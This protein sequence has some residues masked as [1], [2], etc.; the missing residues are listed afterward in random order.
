M[1]N[2]IIR[3]STFLFV[4]ISTYLVSFSQVKI[5]TVYITDA[6]GEKETTNKKASFYRVCKMDGTSL[7]A[8]DYNIDDSIK[9]CSA[10][11]KSF[12]PYVKQGHFIDYNSE[13]KLNFE[14]DYFENE[15]SGTW[16][17]YFPTGERWYTQ[18]YVD[19]HSN[20]FLKSYFKTGEVK[21]VEKYLDDKFVEGNCYTLA[22][23][24][25]AYYEMYIMPSF[26]GGE[27]EKR[28]YFQQNI[29]YPKEARKKGQEG[30]VFVKIR[31]IENGSID[32]SFVIRTSSY[33]LLDD[34]AVQCIQNMPTWTPGY[35]D[36]IPVKVSIIIPVSF[37][38]EN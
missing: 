9:R 1:K 20:G 29:N 3:F 16:T 14:G 28:K 30:K 23:N 13:G 15:R 27:D 25:T 36:G 10:Y 2:K 24:D 6:D 5:D 26:P 17:Y 19:G 7:I 11:Y 34:A 18:D 31:V 35:K 12:N 33:P 21:R 8:V 4:F 38:L 22:G 37:K 32:T